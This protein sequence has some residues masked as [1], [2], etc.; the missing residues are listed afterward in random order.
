MARKRKRGKGLWG[1][2]DSPEVVGEEVKVSSSE[3]EAED[4]PTGYLGEEDVTG[5][6]EDSDEDTPTGY[7]DDEV[8]AED[9]PTG[10]VDDEE[11]SKVLEDSDE[12]TPTGIVDDDEL[13]KE[14]E[15]D[16]EDTPT[17][18]IDDNELA[19]ESEDD[20]EDAA[21]GYVG[22]EV[23]KD[24]V[25][26]V[27]NPADSGEDDDESSTCFV[28]LEKIEGQ[29]SEEGKQEKSRKVEPWVEPSREPAPDYSRTETLSTTTSEVN[30]GT[31][32]PYRAENYDETREFGPER[33]DYIEEEAVA[34]TGPTR[35]AGDIGSNTGKTFSVLD[36]RRATD[37]LVIGEI[38]EGNFGELLPFIKDPNVTDINWNGSQ[39]WIDDIKHGRYLSDV[40]LS[41]DFVEAFAVRISNVVSK[42][43]NKYEPKLEAETPELRITILHESIAP[44]G[45][46]ISI[47]KTPSIKRIT[48]A[49]SI[50]EEMYCPERVANFLSNSVKAKQN[51]VIC[52]LPGVGKTE[53]VKFLTNYIFPRDRVIT[54]E[55]TLELHYPEINPG[56]DCITLKVTPDND[57]NGFTYTEA[58]KVCMR[59]LPQWILLS[60]ARSRE[61]QYLLESASTGAKFITTL[62]TDDVRK[63]PSRVVNMM[64]EIDN[65]TAIEA[66]VYDYFDVGIFLDKKQDPDTGEIVRYISQVCLYNRDGGTNKVVMLYEDGEITNEPIP[67]S[68]VKKYQKVGIRDPW[69][70]TFIPDNGGFVDE[71]ED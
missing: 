44:S 5:I 12:D 63:V 35:M 15:D 3:T 34:P 23:I 54:I 10:I 62:H 55:D 38:Y 53:Y 37:K 71:E 9:T 13:S 11:L 29:N 26:E 39:L 7:V 21:T 58:I 69:E 49:K 48:F 43:F 4:L 18:I 33:E 50:L 28:D 56:K 19:Q 17:G 42:T 22:E 40:R 68:V 45:K 67:A 59:L 36:K 46:P 16:D 51:V 60:E 70:Y 14:S 41:Q 27:K 8:S 6:V 65:A 57:G 25:K 31:V 2:S 30:T 32:T 52:G 24:E 66:M 1:G 20:D 64:G 61:V 47:R